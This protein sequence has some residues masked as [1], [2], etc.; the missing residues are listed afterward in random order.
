MVVKSNGG[1]DATI[2]R[3]NPFALGINW[4]SLADHTASITEA[5]CFHFGQSLLGFRG[6]WQT[7]QKAAGAIVA[8]TWP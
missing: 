5:T 7:S 6:G 1:P 8:E 2:A 4:F 3:M